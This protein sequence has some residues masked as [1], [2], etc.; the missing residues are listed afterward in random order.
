MSKAPFPKCVLVDANFLVMLASDKVSD[1]DKARIDNF[2]SNAEKSKARIVIPMPAVA[3]YLVGADTAAIESFN[4][5][6]RKTYIFVA[7]FDRAAAFECAL[8]DRAALGGGN[9]KDE[10]V[11]PWQKIK[12]DRQIIAIGKAQGV[13]LVISSDDG[14][15]K[16]A[17]RVGISAT[18]VSEL[19]LP[20]SAKQ[21][22]LNLVVAESAKA[23]N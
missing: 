16:N 1:D 14:V 22:R 10:V 17:L 19:E 3:E 7:P 12:I 11:E 20:A 6:E 4:K 15:R 8:L 2:L 9:K 18:T 23:S 21:A 13:T 5:L